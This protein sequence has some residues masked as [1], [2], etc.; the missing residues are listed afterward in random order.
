MYAQEMDVL[1]YAY[2]PDSNLLLSVTDDT[3][4]PKGFNDGNTQNDD[5]EYDNNGNMTVDKTKTS[6]ILLIIT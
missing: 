3:A 5:F 6:K 1:G 4:N 2:K